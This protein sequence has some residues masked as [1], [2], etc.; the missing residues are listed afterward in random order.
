MEFIQVV[1][2]CQPPWVSLPFPGNFGPFSPIFLDSPMSFLE[3][4]CPKLGNAGHLI[5]RGFG[6]FEAF[7]GMSGADRSGS[8]RHTRADFQLNLESIREKFRR[9]IIVTQWTVKWIA[10]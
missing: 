7:W 10:L 8:Q 5:G 3:T 1:V 2:Y 9:Q 6:H 4:T